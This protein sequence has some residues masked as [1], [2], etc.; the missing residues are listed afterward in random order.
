[1]GPRSGGVIN[2]SH[3]LFANDT[4]IISR[5]NPDYLHNLRFALKWFPV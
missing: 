4:L 1:V 3:L 5:A 2:I